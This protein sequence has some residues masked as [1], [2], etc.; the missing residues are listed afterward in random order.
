[1]NAN[2]KVSR[3]F[4]V[5]CTIEIEHTAESLYAH[6]ELDGVEIGPGDLVQ[7]HGAPDAP[8]FGQRITCRSV[9]TVTRAGVVARLGAHLRGYV[10][11]TELYAVGFDG[12]AP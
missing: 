9:A 2:R 7:V 11:L 4:D 5:P 10:E 8:Q 1:M 6:V 3:S 12:S